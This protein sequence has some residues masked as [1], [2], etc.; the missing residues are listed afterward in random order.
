MN[1]QPWHE[2][3]RK[4]IRHEPVSVA[5]IGSDVSQSPAEMLKPWSEFLRA[6]HPRH[7]LLLIDDAGNLDGSS[8]ES[9]PSL[10]LI[11]H[12]R[13]LGPGG[14]LQTAL[15]AAQHPLLLAVRADRRFD[16]AQAYRLFNSIDHGDLI[17]GHRVSGQAPYL[18]RFV[19]GL[20]SWLSRLF[21]GNFLEPRTNW[22]G[23]SSWRRQGMQRWIF[24]V[25]VLDGESGVFLARRNLFD[26][27]PIQSNSYFCFVEVLAKA[28]HVGFMLGE[29]P[30]RWTPTAPAELTSA[31][32]E[33]RT[34]FR[35]PLFRPVQAHHLPTTLPATES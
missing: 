28:N 1:L 12:P 21:L 27:I 18:I 7:E 19:D 5:F 20:R 32:G 29:E 9:I 35:F 30:I 4:P 31:S 3:I 2:N 24:G 33:M 17:V 34:L 25:P 13:P 8:L 11:H 22:L 23:W 15:F 10:R 26:R 16:P 14:A 6:H